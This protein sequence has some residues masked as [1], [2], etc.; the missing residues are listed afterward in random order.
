MEVSS[1][2]RKTYHTLVGFSSIL[3]KCKPLLNY[4]Q[5]LSH[6]W[7]LLSGLKETDSFGIHRNVN[8]TRR[9]LSQS[10]SS[11]RVEIVAEIAGLLG[12]N[13]SKGAGIKFQKN[14]HLTIIVTFSE[15]ILSHQVGILKAKSISLRKN[16]Q[17]SSPTR[18][19]VLLQPTGIPALITAGFSFPL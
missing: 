1:W 10:P 8:P 14:L 6:V 17:T 4:Q 13:S 5:T 9:R 2:F 12:R 15:H 18:M 7:E 3:G 16:S 11:H 19:G